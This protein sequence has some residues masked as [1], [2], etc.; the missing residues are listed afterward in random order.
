MKKTF[1]FIAF[2][3]INLIVL[4]QK[5]GQAKIDSLV[6]ELPKITNDTLKGR[7]IKKIADEYFFIDTEKALQ[8]CKLGLQ[9]VTKMNWNHDALY[10]RLPVTLGYAKVLASTIKRMS[11]MVNKPYEFRFFM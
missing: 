7:T 8:F 4:G 2:S 6:R 11:T 10:D 5:Q 3:L 9:H 1:F